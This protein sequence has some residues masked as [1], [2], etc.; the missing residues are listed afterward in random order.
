MNKLAGNIHLCNIG[1][2]ILLHFELLI[3][4]LI[5]I[6]LSECANPKGNE[7]KSDKKEEKQIKVINLLDLTIL[8]DD[9]YIFSIQ[10]QQDKLQQFR[11]WFP[12]LAIFDR[13][14]AR[15]ITEEV[16]NRDWIEKT[17][18]G[19]SVTGKIRKNEMEIDLKYSIEAFSDE[20]V[21]LELEIRNTGRLP[22]FE[23]AQLA[24]CLAPVSKTFS[25]TVGNRTMIH[26]GPDL[27]KSIK[28]ASVVKNFNHYPVKPRKDNS[29][30]EERIQVE[31]GFVSRFSID[32]ESVISFSWDEA[33]RIDVNPGGLDCIHSHPAIGPLQPGETI[34]RTGFILLTKTN[35]QK[36]FNISQN[37][38]EQSLSH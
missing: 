27:L 26:V 32:K 18:D 3:L 1:S 2:I 21:K 35:T 8:P 11:L 19:Y 14:S 9:P 7:K 5:V 10:F 23:Y 20:A 28:A 24:V 36:N 29:D 34:K 16:T 17:R 22:W 37:L 13:D 6:G 30:P 25:D 38:M 15:A 4:V 33:A 31:S 12:E